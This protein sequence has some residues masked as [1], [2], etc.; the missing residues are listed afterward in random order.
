ME[1]SRV[2]WREGGARFANDRA[3]G[4]SQTIDERERATPGDIVAKVLKGLFFVY[5]YAM[6]EN[7]VTRSFKIVVG[8][9]NAQSI[10]H[11]DLHPS[12]LPLA[13]ESE[14]QK[15]AGP[16]RTKTWK[17]RAQLI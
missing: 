8:D 3:A 9:V 12:L 13:L 4:G 1:L 11:A 10:P 15:V 16:S 7:A 17:R 14:F 2:W 5:A 6:Y